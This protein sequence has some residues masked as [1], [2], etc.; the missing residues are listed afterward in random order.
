[1]LRQVQTRTLDA[2]GI[3]LALSIFTLRIRLAAE[4]KILNTEVRELELR[5][6]LAV[7][8]GVLI[9][10]VIWVVLLKGGAA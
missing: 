4:W 7:A 6:I 2:A 9:G 1:M 5:D 3:L 10:I 8:G